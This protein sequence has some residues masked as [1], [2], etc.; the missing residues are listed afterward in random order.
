MIGGFASSFEAKSA[1]TSEAP[2]PSHSKRATS[3]FISIQLR[4]LDPCV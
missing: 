1:S 3:A 4:L 2:S